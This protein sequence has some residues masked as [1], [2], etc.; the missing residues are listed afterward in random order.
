M[1]GDLPVPELRLHPAPNYL[2]K[3]TDM[4]LVPETSSLTECYLIKETLH[5]IKTEILKGRP[6]GQVIDEAID[7]T[8]EVACHPHRD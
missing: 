5:R 2:G 7:E 4:A 8:L 1:T 3:D 6:S